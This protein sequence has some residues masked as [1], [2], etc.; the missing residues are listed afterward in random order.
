MYVPSH[1]TNDSQLLP[2][3]ENVLGIVDGTNKWSIFINRG[4][5]TAQEFLD[6]HSSLQSKV[7]NACDFLNVPCVGVLSGAASCFGS[8]AADGSCCQEIGEQLGSLNFKV[9]REVMS[10][11]PC[12]KAAVLLHQFDKMSQ[13]WL[14]A[15]PG[16]MSDIPGP[17]FQQAMAWRLNLPSPACKD[18]IGQ[19]IGS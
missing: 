16:P 13:A 10:G 2:S 5:R 15:L 19:K 1:F 14:G 7:K 9:I 8:E 3:L 18:F 6:C 4:S 12:S 11:S 17:E